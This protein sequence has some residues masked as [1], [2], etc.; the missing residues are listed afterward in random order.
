MSK[1]KSNYFSIGNAVDDLRYS[2]GAG[3]KA[4]SAL[5]LFGKS[6]F[7]VG[8]FAVTE[9]LPK[10]AETTANRVKSNSDSSDEQKEKA[11]ELLRKSDEMHKRYGTGKYKE[12]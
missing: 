2:N 10:V 8:A 5:K 7:N 4:K 12:D 6:L 3:E 9:A 11:D 1:K